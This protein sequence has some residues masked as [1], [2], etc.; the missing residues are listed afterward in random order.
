MPFPRALLFLPLTLAMAAAACSDDGYTVHSD[1]AVYPL[2]AMALL[3]DDLPPDMEEQF[4]QTLT[5]RQTAELFSD[6]DVD[7]RVRQ[8]D[9][10][11]RLRGH[12]AV[13]LGDFTLIQSQSTLFTSID[14]ADRSLAVLCDLQQF[15]ASETTEVSDLR[16]PALGDASTGLTI[17]QRNPGGALIGQVVCFRTGRVVHSVLRLSPQGIED[18]SLTYQLARSLLRRVDAAYAQLEGGG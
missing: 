7:A 2:E 4:V 11:G 6:L 1:D 12:L 18:L 13:Y 16:V 10:Q 17:I 15:D 14:A 5:N 8:M 9:A 3:L